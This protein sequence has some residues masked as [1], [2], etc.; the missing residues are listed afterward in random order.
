MRVARRGNATSSLVHCKTCCFPLEPQ[1]LTYFLKALR[2]NVP[3]CITHTPGSLPPPTGLVWH[4]GV[5][6]H[7]SFSLCCCLGATGWKLLG[8]KS[9]SSCEICLAGLHISYCEGQNK[10][11][12]T[13]THKH[14][15]SL[16]CNHTTGVSHVYLSFSC[17]CRCWF[18]PCV[19]C[20]LTFTPCSKLEQHGEA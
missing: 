9:A 7:T 17:G 20:L 3:I 18:L 1:M 5:C 19:R 4:C 8:F 13:L 15:F 16:R 10:D 12:H 11:K 14:T 6:V 2:L